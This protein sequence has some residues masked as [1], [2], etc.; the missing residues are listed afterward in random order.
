[1]S[2][3]DWENINIKELA[4]IISTQLHN[5]DIDAVLVGGACVSIYSKNEYLSH[6]LDYISYSMLK[7]IKPCLDAIGFKQE[8]KNRFVKDECDFYIEFLSPPVAIGKEAPIKNFNQISTEKGEITLLTPTDCVK[9]RLAAYYH[10]GDPQSLEQALLVARRQ[11]INI[12]DIEIWSKGERNLEEY[13]KFLEIL[14]A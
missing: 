12:K 14:N 13:K 6:D 2:K 7:D 3:I 5:N 1:M 9:D 4:G 11:N 8:A 10:W